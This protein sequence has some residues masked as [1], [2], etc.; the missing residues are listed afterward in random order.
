[1][2][3]SNLSDFVV[4]IIT[5]RR[6]DKVHTYNTLRRSGY[7]GQIRLLVDDLDPTQDQYKDK[8][9]DEVIIFDKQ[10]IADTFDNGDNFNDLRSTAFGRNASFG[11]AKSL[12]FRYFIQLDDDYT[13]FHYRYDNRYR[14]KPSCLSIRSMDR[15]LLAMVNFLEKSGA[16]SVAMSQ[17]GDFIGGYQG[18]NA[19]AIRLMRKCMNSFVCSSEREFTFIGR[20]NEDVNPYTRWGSVGYLFF[21]TNQVSLNQIQ[22]QGNSGGM[23]EVYL[24]SGTY[25]KSFYTIMYHPSSVKIRM[26]GSSHRRLH[27]SIDWRRTVPK[28]VSAEHKKAR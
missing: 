24:D 1:M 23:T 5:N 10:A 11:I 3:I 7:T 12:G 27:H 18:K 15:V 13:M 25:V 2:T 19:Q 17:G 14:Y 6:P 16:Y 9:G 26:M 4:F 20:L 22:T 21:T 28:I 8:Y